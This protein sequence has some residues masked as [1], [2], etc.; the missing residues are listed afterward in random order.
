MEKLPKG[1]FLFLVPSCSE[2]DEKGRSAEA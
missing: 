2:E 1:S